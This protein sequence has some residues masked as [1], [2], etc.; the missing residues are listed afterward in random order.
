MIL[1]GDVAQ[2]RNNN[3]N[4]IRALA[5]VAVLVS[6]A[7]PIA[8]GPGAAEPLKA[9]T[10]YSLGNISVQAFFVISG[11]LIA[12]SFERSRTLTR[13]VV[14]RFLRLWPGLIVSILAVALLLGPLVTSLSV[15]A[16]LGESGTWAFVLRNIT[17]LS[18]Q[19][20][21][22]GVFETLPYTDVEGSIWTLLYEVLCYGGLFLLGVLGLLRRPWAMVAVFA[23]YLALYLG[24]RFLDPGLH[25]KIANL[26]KL[27]L[28]FG[29]GTAFYVWRDRVPL[30]LAGV[31]ALGVLAWAM[32]GSPLYGP[33]F[34]LALGYAVFWVAYVPGGFLRAYNR[35]GDYSYGIYIYAFPLQGFAIWL[36]GPM[37]PWQNIALSLPLVLVPSI[38]SWHLVEKPALDLRGRV[39]AWLNP[40]VRAREV[41]PDRRV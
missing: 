15:A 37:S 36:W 17:L 35:L 22:P 34:A 12:Q 18:V 8:L 41:V 1:L 23:A 6:H 7:H 26:I 20:H 38:L 10:G 30:S 40:G 21:L 2:G 24:V 16:Y 28:P 33:T 29:I 27:A 19:F 11:F 39:T 31:V 13:F 9:A 5:A 4:L 14:A 32:Q 25:P 3:F